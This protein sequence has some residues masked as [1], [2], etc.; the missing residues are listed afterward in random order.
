MCLS[1]LIRSK[2]W[3]VCA[4]SHVSD[5]QRNAGELFGP[6]RAA[7]AHARMSAATWLHLWNETPARRHQFSYWRLEDRLGRS[8]HPLLGGGSSSAPFFSFLRQKKLTSYVCLHLALLMGKYWTTGGVGHVD[9]VPY[10]WH[11]RG[12]CKMIDQS[13]WL[14]SKEGNGSMWMEYSSYT[15]TLKIRTNHWKSVFHMVRNAHVGYCAGIFKFSHR[16]STF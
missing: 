9:R 15:K 16:L 6:S 3:C 8:S 2:G 5:V 12:E 7:S 1:F 13:E 11:M 4:A 10:I 14:K